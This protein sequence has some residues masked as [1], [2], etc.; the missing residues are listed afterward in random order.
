MPRTTI[1]LQNVSPQKSIPL[2]TVTVDTTNDMMFLNDGSSLLYVR[3][4]PDTPPCKIEIVAVPDEAGR[5]GDNAAPT[6]YEETVVSGET[7][8]FGPFRQAWW[9]QTTVNIGYVHINIT[10]D[11][12]TAQIAVINY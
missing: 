11:P 1:A 9:N 3:V 6:G 12:A 4:L 7:R 10:Q 8:L 5:T 2:Y